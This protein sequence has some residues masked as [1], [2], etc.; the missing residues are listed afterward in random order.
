MP[1]YTVDLH[2]HTPLIPSDYRGD[3]ATTPR[4]IVERALEVGIDVW[5]IADHFS[6]DYGPKL[7]A[8]AEDVAAETGRRLL[9]LPGAELRVR[10]EGEETH[11]VCLFP[12]ERAD[13]PFGV[14]LGVLGLKSP[15]APLE[16]LP[17]FA[18]DRDPRDVARIVD[19]VGGLCHIGHVDR[20]FGDYC[21]IESDLVH[22]L[23]ERPHV[24]AIE[25]ID[26]SCRERFRDGL[27]IAHISSSDSHSL[28]E[29]G[30]RTATLEMPELSFE[31]LKAALWAA[32]RVA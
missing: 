30:R 5:G 21:F 14:V 9:V 23:A 27:A 24:S 25:L 8:A 11:L 16:D 6:V 7:I 3:P 26:H 4:Q 12:P 13:V 31:G 10:H 15:V 28:D 22:H 32:R 29:M 1:R 18:V 19:A 2:N 20:T 17:F